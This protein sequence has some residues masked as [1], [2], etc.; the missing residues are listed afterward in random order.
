MLSVGATD[1]LRPAGLA[2]P[3]LTLLSLLDANGIPGAVVT[4]PAV[5]A[6]LTNHCNGV[7][8]PSRSPL[9]K[10]RDASA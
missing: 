5:T 1:Q 10:R 7:H 9:S 4:A 2:P 8:E 3:L 6:Y